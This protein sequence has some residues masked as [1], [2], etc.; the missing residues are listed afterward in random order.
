M[1]ISHKLA[2]AAPQPTAPELSPRSVPKT[3]SGRAPGATA[4]KN[5]LHWACL[6]L[7][8]VLYSPEEFEPIS[9]RESPRKKRRELLSSQQS[10][11]S[12]TSTASTLDKARSHPIN[13]LRSQ[14]KQTPEGRSSDES[15]EAVTP[16]DTF[17]F[18][19]SNRAGERLR[20]RMEDLQ[21]Q[22]Q[23]SRAD[24]PARPLLRAAKSTSALRHA[25]TSAQP[26]GA[27]SS[28]KRRAYEGLGVGGKGRIAQSGPSASSRDTSAS[29]L[30]RQRSL[31]SLRHHALSKSSMM[32]KPPASPPRVPSFATLN[33]QA[34]MPMSPAVKRAHAA[35]SMSPQ[36]GGLDSLLSKHLDLA[37]TIHATHPP[38]VTS[39][40]YVILDEDLK[41]K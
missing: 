11:R 28:D 10:S 34:A 16:P 15:S 14:R 24:A 9:Q 26:T 19:Q 5:A 41:Y 13:Q 38:R 39:G 23:Q 29:A 12:G 7:M 21:P 36:K 4:S 33:K 40:A 6:E 31:S 32:Q 25:L 37:D 1:A 18:R 22:A 17:A 30:S 20:V 8:T 27:R 3:P 35:R 2:P